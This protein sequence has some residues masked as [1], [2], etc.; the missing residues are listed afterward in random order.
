MEVRWWCAALPSLVEAGAGGVGAAH[1]QPSW[2]SS[3]QWLPACAAA[4]SDDW[5]SPCPLPA[6]HAAGQRRTQCRRTAWPA[7]RAASCG[8]C[9]WPRGGDCTPPPVQA[10][11]APSP[12][13]F[14][15][16]SR[17]QP[18]PHCASTSVPA[19]RNAPMHCVRGGSLDLARS[20]SVG[21]LVSPSPPTRSRLAQSRCS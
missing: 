16:P 5:S 12:T 21:L 4:Q 11:A 19:S 9:T 17:V 7:H 18:A 3:A 2:P 1:M 10:A 14:S 6:A 20:V 8:C 13:P 15:R